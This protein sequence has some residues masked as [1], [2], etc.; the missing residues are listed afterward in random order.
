MYNPSRRITYVLSLLF[1]AMSWGCM[2]GT[3]LRVPWENLD[4]Y[5]RQKG[6]GGEGMVDGDGRSGSM[7][8]SGS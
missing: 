7:A 3:R 2:Y 4:K 5:E 8:G 6:E 1:S